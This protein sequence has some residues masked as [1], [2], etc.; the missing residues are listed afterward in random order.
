M[1]PWVIIIMASACTRS[2]RCVCVMNILKKVFTVVYDSNLATMCS[3]VDAIV[4]CYC[5]AL[6]C[7]QL[8]SLSVSRFRSLFLQLLLSDHWPPLPQQQRDC[9]RSRLDFT[10]CS[11]ELTPRKSSF[12][13][14]ESLSQNNTSERLVK[15]KTSVDVP[16]VWLPYLNCS[17]PDESA[18]LFKLKHS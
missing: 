5:V 18:S 3:R 4:Q 16:F 17:S 12:C 9:V 6:S 2:Y 13:Q 11:T 8:R 7:E 15:S 10:W 14:H 1:Y